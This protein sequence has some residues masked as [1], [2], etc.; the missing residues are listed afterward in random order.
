MKK[1]YDLIVEPIDE[2]DERTILIQNIPRDK[3]NCEMLK[4]FIERKFKGINVTRITFTYDVETLKNLCKQ[5]VS[6]QSSLYYCE[7][8]EEAYGQPL[9]V[10]PAYCNC[11]CGQ[12]VHAISYYSEQAKEYKVTIQNEVTRTLPNEKHAIFVQLRNEVMAQRFSSIL[13]LGWSINHVK[14]LRVI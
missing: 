1:F 5:A 2:M 14:L 10:N 11:C 3:R 13:P 7:K 8:Y 9:R 6:I 4:E 12:K